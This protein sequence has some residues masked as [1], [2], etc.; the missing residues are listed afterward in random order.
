MIWL[1]ILFFPLLLAFL[2][3]MRMDRRAY[4]GL[5]TAGAAPALAVA[6]DWVPAPAQEI[7]WLLLGAHF[8]LDGPRTLLLGLAAVL[9]MVGGA[10]AAGYLPEDAGRKRFGFFFLL[11]MSGN[12]GLIVAADAATF[13]TFFVVM[14]FAAYGLV[15]HS[16]TA[17]ARRAGR[18]YLVMAIFGEL[19]LIPA[20]Y[21]A[22]QETGAMA[23]AEMGPALGS[24]ENRNTILFLALIGFGVKAGAVPLYFWLPLAH[25]VA[26]TPAS[27]VLSGSMIK[28]GLIGWLHFSPLGQT[29]GGWSEL[30]ILLGLTA[31]FGGVLV[32]LCQTDPK[33]NLAYS[34]ISQMGVMTVIF[35]IALGTSAEL[36]LVLAVLAFY[37][38]NH[39]LAKG[40][41]FLGT[42]L[43]PSGWWGRFA[44]MMGLGSAALAIAGGPFTG[45]AWTKYGAKEVLELG[46]AGWSGTLEV[47]LQCSAVATSLLLGRFLILMWGKWRKKDAASA[48]GGISAWVVLLIVLV[49][50]PYW[51]NAVLAPQIPSPGHTFA[52][53]WDSLWPVALAAIILLGAAWGSKRS[54]K[55]RLPGIPPG[56][57]VVLFEKAIYLTANAR[58]WRLGMVYPARAA[59]NLVPIIDHLL[60][61]DRV[62]AVADRTEQRL[63]LWGVAGTLFLLIVLLLY[64]LL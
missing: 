53:F 5:L 27:A 38:L 61:L 50:A 39:G 49:G 37:A 30:V 59:I 57:F 31:A 44:V 45:G 48:W 12:L 42:A 64:F 20:I 9:W 14:T 55:F 17:E 40:A 23:F 32:G 41:L 54:A 7:D 24:L 43:R 3:W 4:G 15:I 2:A 13:Y 6:L 34:S 47:V 26:P 56:D 11:T 22:V 35:G 62:Q 19:F 25:P 29:T 18:V 58:W 46:P 8:G 16:G 51:A 10:F 36:Q 28:A 60:G 33:T 21:L 52:T 63:A 1:V